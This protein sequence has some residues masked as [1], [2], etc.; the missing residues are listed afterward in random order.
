MNGEESC[1]WLSYRV[2]WRAG[3]VRPGRHAARQ[4]GLGGN[5]RAYR[6]F[7]QLP[8]ARRIDVRRTIADPFGETMVRQ[9]E[10]RSSI[11]VV[12][13]G[14]VSRSMQ[15]GEN[16]SCLH[17]LATLAQAASRSAL[18]SGDAFGFVGFD[19]QI[20][21]DLHAAPSR[22]RGAASAV[23]DRL[24]AL[25]PTGRGASGLAQLASALPDRR[26]LVILASDFLMPPD[27]LETALPLLARHDLAPV[28]LHDA[29]EDAEPPDGILR[30]R[31]AETGGTR[32]VFMRPAL[33]KR[34]REARMAR[35]AA[36]D[37]LFL[38]YC[39]PAFH[40]TGA[41]DVAALGEHLLT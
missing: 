19:E 34:W 23:V 37:R 9:M 10:N 18:R 4:S 40:V 20:R 2:R 32:L 31:D 3:D 12:I 41:L 5:F 17:A 39:R 33:R 14:D 36:L 22:A 13:A 16:A 27:L 15:A 28:V 8:D 30:L 24:R 29:R 11:A 35:R 7:W 21:P 38:R 25:Q 6:P 1:D 26:S